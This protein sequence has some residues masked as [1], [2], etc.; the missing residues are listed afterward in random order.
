MVARVQLYDLDV[1]SDGKNDMLIILEP[2]DISDSFQRA[3]YG[4]RF[5]F[6]ARWLDAPIAQKIREKFIIA[7]VKHLLSIV[8]K[9]HALD[10]VFQLSEIIVMLAFVEN[11]KF[12][13]AAQER[14]AIIVINDQF[15]NGI[16]G[17]VRKIIGQ[18]RAAT[19]AVQIALEDQFIGGLHVI[20]AVF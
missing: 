6:T 19:R 7:P 12:A 11:K 5:V 13:I 3:G 8:G 1:W 16:H 17:R 14:D 2:L 15:G 4:L 9:L 20:N 18:L 10:A